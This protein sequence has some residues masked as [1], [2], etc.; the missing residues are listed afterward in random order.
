MKTILTF[1][2]L[3]LLQTN[4]LANTDKDTSFTISG[5][6]VGF[7]DSSEVKLEDQNTDVQLAHARIIKGKFTLKGKLAEPTLC[8]LK[9]ADDED[10]YIYVENKTISVTG[11]KPIKTNYKVTGSQSHNDF[12]DFKKGLLH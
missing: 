6:M 12:M 3:G 4:L 5:N 10:Q 7:K 2:F 9:I 1:I 8:W 11:I